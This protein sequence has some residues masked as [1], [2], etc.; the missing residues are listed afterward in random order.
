MSTNQ[1]LVDFTRATVKALHSII[2]VAIQKI[3]FISKN[4]EDIRD[5]EL[6]PQLDELIRR[7]ICR[8]SFYRIIC[9]LMCTRREYCVLECHALFQDFLRLF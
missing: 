7:Y 8:F 3:D 1:I 9:S 2:L 5:K 4:I 6:Q